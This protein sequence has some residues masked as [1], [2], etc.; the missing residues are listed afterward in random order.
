MSEKSQGDVFGGKTGL[1]FPEKQGKLPPENPD[2]A[3]GGCFLWKYSFTLW[4]AVET[5]APA[6]Y[7]NLG[8]P[9]A[10]K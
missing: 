9:P 5:P 8:R 7:L 2:P 6:F 1:F 4:G 3:G 10:T